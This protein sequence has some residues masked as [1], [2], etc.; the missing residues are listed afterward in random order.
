MKTVQTDADRRELAPHGTLLC[1]MEVHHDDPG[2]FLGGVIPC[3]WHEE[4]ELSV[5]QQG[6]VEYTL[7][8]GR[9]VLSAGEGILI[10]VNVPHAYVP[11][12]EGN[13]ELLTVIV[14]PAF[15]SGL[16]GSA[17]ECALRPFFRA[18]DLA[19]VPLLSGEIER[20]KELS[21]LEQARP[22]GWELQGKALFCGLFFEL[23]TRCCEGFSGEGGEKV[24]SKEELARLDALL[25][26]LQARYAE[27]LSLADLSREIGMSRENCCRFFKRMTGQT[28][29]QYL[30]T[31]RVSRAIAL[32]QQG[33]SVTSAAM[34]CGFANMGRFAEAFRRRMHCAPREYLRKIR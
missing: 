17:V 3:H 15:L 1:P 14:H 7:G 33:E 32:M 9:R 4:I 25:R 13:V 12:S 18:Q 20:L 24:R 28:L 2:L 11:L 6:R 31:Y 27:P 21:H 29:S 8:G 26:R 19:A 5:V 30:E 23:L 16:P 10:N 22:Y 34:R